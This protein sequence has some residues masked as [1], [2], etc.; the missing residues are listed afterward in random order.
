[1]NNA[2]DFVLAADHRIELRFLGQVGQVPAERAQGRRF[3]VLFSAAGCS[4]FCFGFALWRREIRIELL[5]NFVAG[6]LDIDF[7][8]LQHPGRDA[9]AFAQKS[10]QNVL[11][12]DVRMIQCFRFL[13]GQGQNFFHSWRVRNVADH[14][15]FRAG[16]DLFFDFHANGLEIESHLLQDVDGHPLPEL[17]QPE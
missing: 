10:Q 15:R 11:G 7:E 17:D 16:A 5:Q 9:L 12:P 4:L 3:H 1:M 2:L 14:F 8:T 13:P 6:P